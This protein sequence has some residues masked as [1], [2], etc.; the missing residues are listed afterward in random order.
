[1][2]ARE[3]SLL[4]VGCG[5]LGERAG[6]ALHA[7]GWRVDAVRRDTSRLPPE[8]HPHPADYTC[9]GSLDFAGSLRPDCVLATFTPAG[10]GVEGYRRGFAA[11]ADNLLRGLDGHRPRCVIMVS[12]TRVYAET[13]GGWVDESSALSAGDARALAIAAAERKLLDAKLP[14]TAVRFGGIYGAPGGR[15]VARV[16]RGEISPEAPVRYT[17]RIHRDDAAGFLA[18]LLQEAS[19]GARLAPVYN[20]VDDAPAPAHEVESWLARTL[21]VAPPWR[22]YRDVA[23]G[24]K[25][26]RNQ[27][28]HASGYQLRYPDYRSGYRQV[29]GLD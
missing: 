8:F 11:A 27:L 25:R 13:E 16:A 28:L 9:P 26:C 15:L 29:L 6:L 12:S 10:R 3:P 22:D 14:A 5:D 7:A 17:N 23:S 24:H 1:M 2:P 19:R 20:G 4:I 18:H 21:G